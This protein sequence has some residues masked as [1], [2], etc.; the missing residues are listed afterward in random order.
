M[1]E[2][3]VNTHVRQRWSGC[4]NTCALLLPSRLLWWGSLEVF[5][6]FFLQSFRP[7]ICLKGLNTTGAAR[8]ERVA[9]NH[10]L[11]CGLDGPMDR[12][13][14]AASVRGLQQQPGRTDES[15][16]DPLPPV[17]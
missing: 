11:G 7:G 4:V 13:R 15:S 6:V 12:P 10:S 8:V 3:Y 17:H 1:P 2:P 5:C 16:V 14:F 9:G